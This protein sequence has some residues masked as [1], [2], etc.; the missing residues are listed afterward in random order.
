MNK[1]NIVGNFQDTG[2]T[3]KDIDKAVEAVFFVISNSELAI[4]NKGTKP[5]N[6][7]INVAFVGA[8]EI[9][10]H[11]LEYRKKDSPTDVL[12]FDY[13]DEGDILLCIEIIKK[14]QAKDEGLREAAIN[15]LVH[16]SLHLFGFDHENDYDHA[17][18]EKIQSKVVE[19]I[20]NE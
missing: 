17:I 5:E 2:L 20:K 4:Q 11:N 1:V 19:K 12:S 9:K 3:D 18:M 8:D 13:D 14:Y 10:K 15:T 7:K 6:K 16:G